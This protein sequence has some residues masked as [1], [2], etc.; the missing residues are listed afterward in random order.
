MRLWQRSIQSLAAA[1]SLSALSAHA[2][3][4]ITP[5]YA[6]TSTFTAAEKTAISAAVAEIEGLFS[7]PITVK[8]NFTNNP[9]G[10]GG[11]STWILSGSYT[12]VR[13]LLLADATTATDATAYA[14]LGAVDPFFSSII[15]STAQCRAI[16]GGCGFGP[17]GFDGTININ[18]TLTDPTRGNGISPGLYDMESVVE[19]EIDEIL[20]SGSWLGNPPSSFGRVQDLFRYNAAGGRTYTTAGNDAYLSVDGGLTDLARFNQQAGPGYGDFFSCSHDVAPALR[21]QNA[22]GTPGVEVDYSNVEATMMDVLGYDRIFAVPEPG[23]LALVP[24]AFLVALLARRRQTK[25][26]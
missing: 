10:L 21:V 1:A 25:K 23:T 18:T 22:C 13:G 8:I 11:S 4:V 2:G 6:P 14:T 5:F 24:P 3:L 7:D 17:D 16:G 12:T 9:V 15:V 20:G 26:A 19:H